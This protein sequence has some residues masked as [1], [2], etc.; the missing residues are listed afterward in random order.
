MTRMNA[1]AGTVLAAIALPCLAGVAAA[2]AR[3]ADPVVRYASV[4]GTTDAGIFIAEDYGLFK[5]A[6]I[7]VKYQRLENAAALL[8]AI[9]TN[10]L[11]VAGVSLT[12]GLFA[13][14]HQG[15][16]LR[17]VGDKQSMLPGF[18]ATQLVARQDLA[19]G[20][21]AEALAR[22]KGKTVSISGRTSVS[23]FLVNRLLRKY[24]M[25]QA[26][27]RF[28]ELSYA[29]TLP[30]IANRAI[31]G[32]VELEP[33][34]TNA[35]ATGLVKPVSDFIEVVPPVGASIVPIVYGEKFV[36][37]RRPAEAFM[38]AYMKAVR[39]YMDAYLKN[40]DKE[41]VIAL[42]A[43]R[44]NMAPDIIRAGTPTGFEPNQDVSAEFLDEAQRFHLEQRFIPAL[45][46]VNRLVDRS[47][48]EAALRQLGPYK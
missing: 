17:V 13:S 28:V 9:A 36:A 25:S 7:D 21:T 35:L 44:T 34:L 4:G 2:P 24:G 10:Q 20:S 16:E 45:I 39:I 41:R 31:D 38:L 33:Y 15:I 6:G 18:A 8:A 27:L 30:A 47:F 42:I 19:Q 5:E 37:N 46:D 43:R 3:A 23:F 22:L 48:A 11:D 14:L 32:A 29:N 12:P 40:V 1:W 26:D